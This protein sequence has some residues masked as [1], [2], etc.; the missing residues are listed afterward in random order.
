MSDDEPEVEQIEFEVPA[1]TAPTLPTEHVLNNSVNFF[2]RLVGGS[3]Q[4]KFVPL[5]VLPDGRSVP[6]PEAYVVLFNPDS[7]E[8]FKREVA[9]DGMKAP[10]IE[11]V[12]HF[13]GGLLNG[14]GH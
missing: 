8:R 5:V 7:W 6:A 13:P 11:T 2:Q 14:D 3:M 1:V 10:G 12:R 9:A 4:L